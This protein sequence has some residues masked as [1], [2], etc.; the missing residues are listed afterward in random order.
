MRFALL[1]LVFAA[2]A[3]FAQR[4]IQPEQV[5]ASAKIVAP[6]GRFTMPV[7]VP[8]NS[9]TMPAVK[10]P[11]DGSMVSTV[12]PCGA[13]QSRSVEMKRLILKPAPPRPANL[14]LLPNPFAPLA[15]PA[16]PPPLKQ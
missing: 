5:C 7:V 16:A 11:G 1:C 13:A 14:Q 8:G 4:A 6:G 2:P 10:P 12:P 9:F 3:C 15:N